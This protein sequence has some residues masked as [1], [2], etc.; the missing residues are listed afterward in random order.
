MVL[1][2]SGHDRR[3]RPLQPQLRPRALLEGVR[4]G[5]L[6]MRYDNPY[7]ATDKAAL[8][9]ALLAMGV[10]P[11]CRAD[12]AVYPLADS[13]YI[14]RPCKESWYLPKEETK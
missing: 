6:V 11:N 9:N 3:L 5:E 14:C 12:L 1:G 10:C 8:S 7:S 2:R 13:V 4:G